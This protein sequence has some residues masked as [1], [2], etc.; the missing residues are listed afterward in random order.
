MKT[1][2]KE[3][4]EFAKVVHRQLGVPKEYISNANIVRIRK[5]KNKFNNKKPGDVF[6][7]LAPVDV[8][9]H[10]ATQFR[11]L[12][13]GELDDEFPS[14]KRKKDCIRT[15]ANELAFRCSCPNTRKGLRI[16]ATGANPW[17]AMES[18]IDRIEE[19]VY[20]KL[21]M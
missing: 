12:E 5:V 8:W 10:L 7:Y 6:G 19:A 11:L 9:F 16:I 4:D 21:G 3:Y 1:Q 18:N 17:K 15:V 13:S 14:F 2:Q 20:R